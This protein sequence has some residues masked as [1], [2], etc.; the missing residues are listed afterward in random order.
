MLMNRTKHK[1]SEKVQCYKQIRT[2]EEIRYWVKL[3]LLV[4]RVR[5]VITLKI[6]K[7][8]FQIKNNSKK[9]PCLLRLN[10]SSCWHLHYLLHV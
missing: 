6:E 1:T 9:N 8:C 5:S 10:F 4:N 2:H 7:D 3:A